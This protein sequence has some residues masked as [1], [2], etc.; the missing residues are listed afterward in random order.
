MAL[1]QAGREM[2]TREFHSYNGEIAE[3]VFWSDSSQSCNMSASWDLFGGL[4]STVFILL[5]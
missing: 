2:V 1:D 5:D 3:E 4:Q